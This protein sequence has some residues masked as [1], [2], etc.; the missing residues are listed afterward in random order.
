MAVRSLGRAPAPF[1]GLRPATRGAVMTT[2]PTAS[3]RMLLSPENG[4]NMRMVAEP[5]RA[6]RKKHRY[7]SKMDTRRYDAIHQLHFGRYLLC[8]E[9]RAMLFHVMP[10]AT[11]CWTAWFSRCCFQ[12][13]G[14]TAC[15]HCN[16]HGSRQICSTVQF[17]RWSLCLRPSCIPSLL[18]LKS[19]QRPL[20]P[21]FAPQ[22]SEANASCKDHS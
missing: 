10:S 22:A 19:F 8:E 12:M 7:S 21:F 18:R 14:K 13:L 6:V 17:L 3:P 1:S 2:R 20:M 9:S 11:S 16:D 4:Q 5:S 15:G